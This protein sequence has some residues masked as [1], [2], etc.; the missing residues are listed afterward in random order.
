MKKI[1]LVEDDLDLSNLYKEFL[2]ASGFEVL[3][4]GDKEGG[5]KMTLQSD[6]DFILLDVMLA[7]DTSGLDLLKDLRKD[8]K[9]K[10]IPV[11]VL[12]NVAKNEEKEKALKLG[13][14]EYLVKAASK[15]QEVV[16]VAKKYTGLNLS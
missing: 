3:T 16:K 8:E 1:L 5:L 11:V 13:A 14:K 15:P 7:G 2:S 12:T 10:D 9:G 6:V 4:A